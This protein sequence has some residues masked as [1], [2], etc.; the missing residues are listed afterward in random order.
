[1]ITLQ[2]QLPHTCMQNWNCDLTSLN[3]IFNYLFTSFN[4]IFAL[5][6]AVMGAGVLI[7]TRSLFSIPLILVGLFGIVVG[8]I[9]PNFNVLTESLG[10]IMIL[11]FA[12]I[13]Y[14]IY[15]HL[16]E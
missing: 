3:S 1:M 4:D 5:V 7:R 15:K 13:M 16:R 14:I 2:I 6:L 11:A 9:A 8:R 12:V 10:V